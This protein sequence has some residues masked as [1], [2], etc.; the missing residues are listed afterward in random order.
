[1]TTMK[2]DIPAD[3]PLDDVSREIEKQI[4]RPIDESKACRDAQPRIF[5]EFG[6]ARKQHQQ[7]DQHL[8]REAEEHSEIPLYHIELPPLLHHVAFEFVHEFLTTGMRYFNCLSV[9]EQ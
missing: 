8:G 1:M 4:A 6:L 3:R 5:P 9:G 2:I 7:A